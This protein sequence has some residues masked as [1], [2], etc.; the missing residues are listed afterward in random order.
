MDSPPKLPIDSMH[1]TAMRK[2]FLYDAIVSAKD[3][4]TGGA[5]YTLNGV[6]EY[7]I[8]RT[9]GKVAKR[10]EPVTRATTI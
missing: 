1:P 6:Q 3:V 7:L 2:S 10:P 5:L 9:T 8:A 4:D